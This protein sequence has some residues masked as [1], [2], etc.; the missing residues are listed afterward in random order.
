MQIYHTSSWFW[1]VAT[2]TSTHH[3]APLFSSLQPPAAA[4]SWRWVVINNL[5]WEEFGPQ[6]VEERILCLMTHAWVL[7]NQISNEFNKVYSS[8]NVFSNFLPKCHWR[9][10]LR[11]QRDA[12]AKKIP[13]RTS[14]HTSCQLSDQLKIS[15]LP[16]ALRL[17]TL[18][19]VGLPGIYHSIF[20]IYQSIS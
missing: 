15:K 8:T 6:G 18:P 1:R 14:M 19:L 2:I 7:G 13:A 16:S 5:G 12:K 10:C 11:S 4:M 9:M 3:S 20:T 17:C